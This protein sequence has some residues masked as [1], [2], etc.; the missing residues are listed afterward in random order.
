MRTRVLLIE[1]ARED[2]EARARLADVF[3]RPLLVV[4]IEPGT[5]GVVSDYTPGAEIIRI[6]FP[7]GSPHDFFRVLDPK[8]GT[9]TCASVALGRTVFGREV[10]DVVCADV[11]LA[12]AIAHA[13]RGHDVRCWFGASPCTPEEA[14]RA[15]SAGADFNAADVAAAIVRARESAP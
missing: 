11:S 4:R 12:A 10:R 3:G 1:S 7:P 5:P 9:E 6:G 15:A 13:L 14:P 8:P 2:D